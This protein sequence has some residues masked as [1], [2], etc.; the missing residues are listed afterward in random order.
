MRIVPRND[1]E[2]S[3]LAYMRLEEPLRDI[4][5]R[6]A[7]RNAKRT[8]EAVASLLEA[9]GYDG[10]NGT[11]ILLRQASPSA[12]METERLALSLQPD[13]RKA[14][15][16]RLYGQIGTGSYTLRKAVDHLIRFGM[17]QD[18]DKLYLQGQ[19]ALRE[20]AT[21]GMLRGE[22]AV[23]KGLGVGWQTGTPNLRGVDAFLKDRWSEREATAYLKPMAKVVRDEVTQAILVGESPQRMSLRIRKVEEINKVR[24]DRNARTITTAVANEAQMSS[25]TRSGVKKY[26]WVATFDERTCPVCGDR[27]GKQYPIGQG[28]YPPAHP[29]CRCTTKAVLSKAV[30]DRLNANLA[31]HKDDYG[32]KYIPPEMHY[33][34]WK[35]RHLS[36][37][38]VGSPLDDG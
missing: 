27:D 17:V 9:H 7:N 30:Q 23:Q 20:T 33:S 29:N 16:S 25:Y 1:A 6:F 10:K 22:F 4:L 15:L 18:A 3:V 12:V 19:K 37:K 13:Q 38:D 28:E 35:Q 21:E 2:E 26:E 14:L 31:K 8:I 36:D 24:A 11:T 32:A 5:R 34:E